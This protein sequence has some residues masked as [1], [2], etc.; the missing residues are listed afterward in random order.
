MMFGRLLT[1]QAARDLLYQKLIR[2]AK[3]PSEHQELFCYNCEEPLAEVL[4]EL[5]AIVF[6]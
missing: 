3:Q 5:E 6:P 4:G 1:H 2:S